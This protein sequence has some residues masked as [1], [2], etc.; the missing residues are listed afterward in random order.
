MLL[1]SVLTWGVRGSTLHLALL[2]TVWAGEESWFS[3]V[4]G[5]VVRVGGADKV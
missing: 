1:P 3:Q 2:S 5:K 4:L